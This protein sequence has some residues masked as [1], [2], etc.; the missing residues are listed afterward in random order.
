MSASA[1]PIVINGT[2]AST[3][4]ITKHPSM[5][6]DEV[7][8]LEMNIQRLHREQQTKF[9]SLT[10]TEITDKVNQYNLAEEVRY[11]EEYERAIEHY[12]Q[13]Y[14]PI[15]ERKTQLEALIRDEER[16]L[17]DLGASRDR[18]WREKLHAEQ[19]KNGILLKELH[20]E[21]KDLRII[22]P[23]DLK[24]VYEQIKAASQQSNL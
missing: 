4:A 14:D 10:R 7:E 8:E 5:T 22:L 9:N 1:N 24:K 13:V 17:R 6:V 11:K 20:A 21:A 16:R 19:A 15:E 2:G 3:V 12:K 23:N 18:E